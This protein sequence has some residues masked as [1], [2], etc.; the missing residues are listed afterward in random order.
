MAWGMHGMGH[1]WHGACM[2]WGMHGMGHAQYGACTIWGM[3]GMGHAQ[4][5]ACMAWGM[6]GHTPLILLIAPPSSCGY[7][8]A[9]PGRGKDRHSVACDVAAAKP[10]QLRRHAFCER[11]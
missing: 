3:H 9:T 6:H 2:A 11:P 1:A 8:T 4:Y 7:G 5:G 10:Q